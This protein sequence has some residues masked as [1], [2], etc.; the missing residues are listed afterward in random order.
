MQNNQKS[1]FET[2]KELGQCLLFVSLCIGS[3]YFL[4]C[5]DRTYHVHLGV[6]LAI[7]AYG[8]AMHIA[9][10]KEIVELTSTTSKTYQHEQL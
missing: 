6:S 5:E 7:W 2:L 1:S 8:V 3:F 10:P 9:S 4:T